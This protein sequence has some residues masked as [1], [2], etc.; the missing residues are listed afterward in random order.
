MVQLPDVCDA[1]TSTMTLFEPNPT[2]WRDSPNVLARCFTTSSRDAQL[3]R[4]CA[5]EVD[6]SKTMAKRHRIMDFI[7][8]LPFQWRY[9]R[10]SFCEKRMEGK[11]S[12]LG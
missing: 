11:V 8:S 9:S 4:V 1:K 6:E 2:D 12:K 3:A 5:T 10:F 7:M